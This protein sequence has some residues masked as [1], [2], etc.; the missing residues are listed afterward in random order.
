MPVARRALVLLALFA[1]APIASANQRPLFRKPAR[2]SFASRLSYSFGA[3]VTQ[4]YDRN[5]SVRN[6]HS[7][8]AKLVRSKE[9]PKTVNSLLA[10][11][12]DIARDEVAIGELFDV[13]DAAQKHVVPFVALLG[14]TTHTLTD[15]DGSDR[16]A[17]PEYVP[18]GHALGGVDKSWHLF[19]HAMFAFVSL[20]D[21]AFG[22]GEVAAHFEDIIEHFDPHGHGLRL[23]ELNNQ[24]RGRLG[25][26]LPKSLWGPP[27]DPMD[28]AVRRLSLSLTDAENRVV[29]FANRAGAAH[30]LNFHSV[31]PS[32]L[33]PAA[34]FDPEAEVYST[35]SADSGLGDVTVGRELQVNEEGAHLGVLW[36]RSPELVPSVP[37]S[38]PGSVSRPF[39]ADQ[40][41][42]WPLYYARSS[43]LLGNLGG[44]DRNSNDWTPDFQAHRL[45]ALN[46]PLPVSRDELMRKM[47]L[48]V[49][50]LD[51]ERLPRFYANFAVR[52]LE[53][54]DRL[55]YE[56]R[57][58]GS[59]EFNLH[60]NYAMNADLGTVLQEIERRIQLV[61]D[62]ADNI[63]TG[64]LGAP[65]D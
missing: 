51:K 52:H 32:M 63:D 56:N 6:T 65:S 58:Q 44:V 7:R 17:F 10:A 13:P 5:T 45:W 46:T 43:I 64:E 8:L 55:H 54:G 14:L 25:G 23:I 24:R 42:P 36:W 49:N 53:W 30:E 16:G 4:Q 62:R 22:D 41:I 18:T 3:W 1:V 50:S 38:E 19:N 27:D 61:V 11:A 33:R 29:T 20:Y 35:L 12:V 15:I 37:N 39:A 2:K 48:Q 60:E 26:L 21:R 28:F 34:E 9:R 59:P 31:E 57:Y 47:R 40:P